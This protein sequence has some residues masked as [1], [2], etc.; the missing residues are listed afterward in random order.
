MALA[1][2]PTTFGADCCA[3]ALGREAL[4]KW[5]RRR[6]EQDHPYWLTDPYGLK[7]VLLKRIVKKALLKRFVQKAG[8]GKKGSE[9]R[10]R[11]TGLKKETGQ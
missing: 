9:N 5:R 2:S 1:R 4:T 8:L 6:D 11:K 3:W 7:I 10:A